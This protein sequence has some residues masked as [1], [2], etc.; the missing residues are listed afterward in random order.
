MIPPRT[1]RRTFSSTELPLSGAALKQTLEALERGQRRHRF[2]K[3]GD[4]V[5]AGISGGADSIA[6][7]HLLALLRRKYS[8]R[9]YAAHLNHRLYPRQARR[10]ESLVKRTAA[11][12]GV[13]VRTAAADIRRISARTGRSLED[14]ARVER[15]RF[16]EKV[17]SRVG[18]NKIAT[19]HT[20]DDQAETML[21]RLLRGSGLRGL[22]AIPP[23]RPQGRFELIRPLIEV[24]KKDLL[25]FLGANR[26]RFVE[27]ASNR[28]TDFTRN[29]VRHRLLPMLEK[30]F[31]PRIKRS[32]SALQTIAASAQNYLEQRAGA[33]FR[34]CRV[35]ARSKRHVQL[36]VRR[37]KRLPQALLSEV[38]FCA[39]VCRKGHAH[40]VTHEHVSGIVDMLASPE[41]ALERHLPGAMNVSLRGDVL[42]IR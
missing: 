41:T 40:R 34:R 25:G 42:R 10:Q 19:A 17:A 31:N 7:L 32:L 30:D 23:K 29:R 4:V 9:V 36:D 26:I 28:D 11:S 2:F 13:P 6:L 39:I 18:A 3:K 15:Y 14:A 22:S 20:L 35:H 27:D 5:V 33:A 24:P 38:L 16:F 37:L 12:L 21:M 1:R 8:L